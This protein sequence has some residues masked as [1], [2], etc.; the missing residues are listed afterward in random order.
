MGIENGSGS[1][2]QVVIES[3]SSEQVWF[4]NAELIS[5]CGYKLEDVDHDVADKSAA[6]ELAYEWGERIPIGIFYRREGMPTYEEQVPAL[7]AGPLVKQGLE[8]LRPQQVEALRAEL[9]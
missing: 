4:G 1:S 5:L 8:K 6:W 9:I 7:K 2:I 3:G